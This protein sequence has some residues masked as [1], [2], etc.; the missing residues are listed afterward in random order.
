MAQSLKITNSKCKMVINY[1][2]DDVTSDTSLSV[3][4]HFLLTAASVR[5]IG[6]VSFCCCVFTIWVV[7]VIFVFGAVE[8]RQMSAIAEESDESN[9]SD[10][11][12]LVS[13]SKNKSLLLILDSINELRRP[14]IIYI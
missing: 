3:T 13:A 10:L 9:I 4:P 6:L 2:S 11:G 14:I 12:F 5:F 1:K 7:L 8:Q